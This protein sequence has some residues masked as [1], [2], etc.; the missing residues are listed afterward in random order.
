M[1]KLNNKNV[2]SPMRKILL[3]WHASGVDNYH[4]RFDSLSKYFKL[5]V[6]VSKDFKETITIPNSSKYKTITLNSFL[7]F[8]ASLFFYKNLSSLNFSNY[9]IIYI[10]EEPYSLNTF[11]IALKAYKS[12][13]P[14][15]L[16]SAVIN[17]RYNF[18]G[19]NFLERFVLNNA[20][21]VYYRNDEVKNYLLK[22]GLFRKQLISTIPNG[23]KIDNKVN[24][25]LV[26]KN[27]KSILRIGYAGKIRKDKGLIVLSNALKEFKVNYFFQFCGIIEEKETYKNILSI[28]PNAKYL[29]VL[30]ADQMNSFYE[31]LDIL[32]L[33]S[34]PTEKWTEQFGRVLTEAISRGVYACGSRVGFIPEIVGQENTFLPNNKK[35][36]LNFLNKIFHNSSYKSE[37][38]YQYKT[39]VEKYSWDS[40]SKKIKIDFKKI[41]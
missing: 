41:L 31:D 30:D 32:I 12:K 19:F 38:H 6:V 28:L 5:T 34:I 24:N 1:E 39:L 18:Y 37:L 9:D 10:H 15:V 35:E 23:V 22:R 11:Q 20:L 26:K 36:L 2:E 29:G 21:G 8:H 16:D 33:P 27:I 40:I 4:D 25:L 7:N 17:M 3:F 14:Y 13:T